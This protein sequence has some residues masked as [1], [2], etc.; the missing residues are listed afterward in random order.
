MNSVDVPVVMAYVLDHAKR[1][2]GNNYS[3]GFIHMSQ[4][5]ECYATRGD[6]LD[7][8]EAAGFE[9]A[10]VV[11]HRDGDT[12]A[13]TWDLRSI[14]AFEADLSAAVIDVITGLVGEVSDDVGAD[15]P[16]L[17]DIDVSGGFPAVVDMVAP[18]AAP[19]APVDVV[20]HVSPEIIEA[21]GMA[22]LVKAGL[23]IPEVAPVAV[24][25]A[26]SLDYV[27]RLPGRFDETSA[28]EM[29]TWLAGR[30][31]QP[32]EVA[33]THVGDIGGA[34]VAKVFPGSA[35]GSAVART[36][37][38]ARGDGGLGKAIA[39]MATRMG[40]PERDW[41]TYSDA[42]IPES[43]ASCRK[44]WV[45]IRDAADALDLDA[46]LAFDFAGA[47]DTESGNTY[48]KNNGRYLRARIDR[49][50]PPSPPPLSNARP[51]KLR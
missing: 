32:V 31:G 40:K 5:Q 2:G 13:W 36:P 50:S 43:N 11:A 19:T 1:T 46:L 26:A 38:V 48:T 35:R 27:V 24:A 45:A 22:G 9:R 20:A 15:M 25:V 4:T 14:P 18:Q 6:A 29:A 16:T 33:T 51:T 23:V 30:L 37:S 8:G 10:D 41:S 34:V 21:F 47:H 3:E 7:A 49:W 42:D 28:R 44:T 12:D 17:T 39:E